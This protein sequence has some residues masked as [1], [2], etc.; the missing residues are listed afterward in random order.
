M[1]AQAWNSV[2]QAFLATLASIFAW[3]LTVILLILIFYRPILRLLNAAGE[4]LESKGGLGSG[5]MRMGAKISAVSM[6]ELNAMLSQE[7]PSEWEKSGQGADVRFTPVE[8]LA[9]IKCSA[10]NSVAD[11][12]RIPII[13]N[14]K[15]T[16]QAKEVYDGAAIDQK[17]FRIVEAKVFQNSRTA[18]GR[19]RRTLDSIG[20]F[21]STVDDSGK[22]YVNA[23]IVIVFA[24]GFDGDRQSTMDEI[25]K[26]RNDYPF[27]IS[28]ESFE[29]SDFRAV[30]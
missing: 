27:Y 19:I 3:P 18:G 13:R 15:L 29:E 22:S 21:M 30:L 14:I 12:I 26:I 17:G 6:V 25:V 7:L 23:I 24:E 9:S 28:I 8:R 11:K 20:R 1:I 4:R 5:V 16:P 2:D 10:L